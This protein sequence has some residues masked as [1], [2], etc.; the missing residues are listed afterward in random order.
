MKNETSQ[1][2]KAEIKKSGILSPLII[3]LLLLT[4]MLILKPN[5]LSATNRFMLTKVLTITALVGFSQ[6]IIMAIGGLNISVGAIGAL[7]A[8]VAG[9]AMDQFGVPAAPAVLIGFSVGA[10]CGAVNGLLIYRAGG[11]GPAFFLITLA[12]ASLFQGINLTITSGN[13]YYGIDPRFIAYGDTELFG[14]PLSFFYM[15]IVAILISI[16][17][18]KLTIGRQF[19][20]YGGNP[21]ASEIYG[22]SKFR[23]VMYASVIAA[24]IAS[25]AGMTAMIRIK[26]AQPNMGAEWMLVSFAAPLIGGSKLTGGKIN[27][28]GCLLGAVAL[29]IIS[30]GLVHLAVDVFWNTL[31]YGSV[32]LLSVMIDQLHLVNKFRRKK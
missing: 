5:Y 14:I 19:L 17:F 3:V 31:I 9:G 24:L 10:L 4:V 21:K 20:A 7:S 30:N 22:I 28:A 25:L 11:V 13:P 26:T 27:V 15:I 6:M 1:N 12:T 29:T 2:I 23:V 18:S 16:M 32:I 8:I